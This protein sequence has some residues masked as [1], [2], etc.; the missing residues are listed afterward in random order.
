[1]Y[2]VNLICQS[3]NLSCNKAVQNA[4]C[5]FAYFCAG[6]TQKKLVIIM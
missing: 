6:H 2:I 5:I 4:D 3:S 1:M